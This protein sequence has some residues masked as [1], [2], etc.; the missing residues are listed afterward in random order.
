MYPSL[1]TQIILIV[2]YKAKKMTVPCPTKEL[3]ATPQNITDTTP[4]TFAPILTTLLCLFLF[5][6]TQIQVRFV[7]TFQIN[8]Y[9][10]M[11]SGSLIFFIV[12]LHGG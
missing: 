2:C 7:E 5:F 3:A 8:M 12:I 10:N 4:L 9:L 1:T 6:Y 11:K